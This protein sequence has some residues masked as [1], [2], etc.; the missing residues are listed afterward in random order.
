MSALSRAILWSSGP[1]LHAASA[2]AA[3]ADS[4]KLGWI[5]PDQRLRLDFDAP[6]GAEKRGDDDHRRGRADGAE[7]FAMNRA[8]LVGIGGVGD[9][10]ARPHDVGGGAAKL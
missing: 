2:S 6:F 7:Q 9:V 1:W 4:R 8:D 10:H 3:A 5:I